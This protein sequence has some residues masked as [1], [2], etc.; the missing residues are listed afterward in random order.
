M[1]EEGSLVEVKEKICDRR[2]ISSRGK[3]ENL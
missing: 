2:R 1:V 3:G